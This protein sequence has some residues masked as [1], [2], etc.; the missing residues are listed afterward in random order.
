M[1]GRVIWDRVNQSVWW[2]CAESAAG[3]FAITANLPLSGLLLSA[4]TV[5]LEAT[6]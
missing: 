5:S 1:L 6:L 3:E 4:R 2:L